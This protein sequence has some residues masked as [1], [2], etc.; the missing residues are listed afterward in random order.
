MYLA[1]NLPH[2]I[3]TFGGVLVLTASYMISQLLKCTSIPPH[4]LRRF[5]GPKIHIP[6]LFWQPLVTKIAHIACPPFLL[7]IAWLSHP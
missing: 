4:L 5:R 2:H 6:I 3:A 7:P 1:V